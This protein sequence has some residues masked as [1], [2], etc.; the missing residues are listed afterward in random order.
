[1]TAHLVV[2]SALFNEIADVLRAYAARLRN[3]R[4]R[5]LMTGLLDDAEMA[6]GHPI[7]RHV[8]KDMRYLEMRLA[9]NPSLDVVSTFEHAIVAERATLATLNVNRSQIQAWLGTERTTLEVSHRFDGPIGKALYRGETELVA[10]SQLKVFM[11]RNPDSP[12]GFIV[13]TLKLYK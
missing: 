3:P 2:R 9:A 4:Q 1:M 12:L 11:T 5:N 8:G 7:S 6:G 13:H 10:A